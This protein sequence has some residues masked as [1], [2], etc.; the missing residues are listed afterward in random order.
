MEWNEMVAASRLTLIS[1]ALYPLLEKVWFIFFFQSCI[2][3]C[4]S[5]DAIRYYQPASH[6]ITYARKKKVK[7]KKNPTKIAF[8]KWMKTMEASERLWF[9]VLS[10]KFDSFQTI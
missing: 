2:Y 3:V 7:K 6:K 10:E 9:P 8:W 4:S 1:A 5:R